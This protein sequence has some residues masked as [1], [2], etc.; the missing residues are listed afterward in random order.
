MNHAGIFELFGHTPTVSESID[1]LVG[2]VILGGWALLKVLD[3]IR[4]YLK[5]IAEHLTGQDFNTEAEKR[6]LEGKQRKAKRLRE[7]LDQL[8]A[9]AKQNPNPKGYYSRSDIETGIREKHT[10]ADPN[11]VEELLLKD[12]YAPRD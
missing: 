12:G 9:R 10:A 5:A 2:A 7:R 8:R 1:A 4:K 6:D 3:D 11:R